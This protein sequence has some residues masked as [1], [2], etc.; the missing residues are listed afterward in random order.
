MFPCFHPL[1]VR[2]RKAA[3]ANIT[4][5][6]PPVLSYIVFIFFFFFSKKKGIFW[7]CDLKK[8]KQYRGSG[9]VINMLTL[10]SF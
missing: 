10:S 3:V 2:V 5:A 4:S 6:A 8:G 7:A 1:R 9:V